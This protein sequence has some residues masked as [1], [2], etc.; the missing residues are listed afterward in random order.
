[1]LNYASYLVSEAERTCVH[2]VQ[3]K[4]QTGN[5]ILSK[6]W[7]KSIQRDR[8]RV[9]VLPYHTPCLRVSCTDKARSL[10]HCRNTIARHASVSSVMG[11]RTESSASAFD[12]DAAAVQCRCGSRPQSKGDAEQSH[13]GHALRKGIV[14]ALERHVVVSLHSLDNTATVLLTMFSAGP[15]IRQVETGCCAMLSP[16]LV[17][18][19]SIKVARSGII[20]NSFQWV[21]TSTAVSN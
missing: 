19:R 18:N 4:R 2:D 9:T 21:S 17:G 13:L 16:A 5:V 11:K 6:Q 3:V 7:Y 12:E 10:L 14:Q 20:L 15:S 8:C 1:M